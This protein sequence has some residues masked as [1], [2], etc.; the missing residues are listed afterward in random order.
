MNNRFHCNSRNVVYLITCKTCRKQYVGS[1]TTKFRLRCNN[2]KSN[3]DKYG[4]G[5]RG[6]NQESLYEHFHQAD[7]TGKKDQM[8]FQIIDYCDP[9]DQERRESFWEFH[10]KPALNDAKIVIKK[11]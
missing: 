2:Y 10:L 8:S 7:H 3:F 5:E 6:M 1:T 4:K 9:N 11:K